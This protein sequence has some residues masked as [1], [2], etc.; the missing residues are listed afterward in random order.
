MLQVVRI[1]IDIG[2]G[3]PPSQLPNLPGSAMIRGHQGAASASPWQRP[4][5]AALRTFRRRCMHPGSDRH[6]AA[7]PRRFQWTAAVLGRFACSSW[8]SPAPRSPAVPSIPPGRT[9][10]VAAMATGHTPTRRQPGEVGTAMV[11][12]DMATAEDMAAV[13]V[14]VRKG[15]RDRHHQASSTSSS[16]SGPGYCTGD[17]PA[18]ASTLG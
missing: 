10:T 5:P 1:H 12:E 13:G 14:R 4:D 7:A 6:A 8:P 3:M 17:G 2:Y 11:A 16:S 15:L 9:V 18:L